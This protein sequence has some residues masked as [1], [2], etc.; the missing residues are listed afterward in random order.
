M[1]KILLIPLNPISPSNAVWKQ[2]YLFLRIFSVQYC[3]SLK[4]IT[5]LETQNIIIRALSKA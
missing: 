5:P 1:G 4:Y 3:H 2:K